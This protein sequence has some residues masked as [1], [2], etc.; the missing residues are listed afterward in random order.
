MISS[1]GFGCFLVAKYSLVFNFN[2]FECIF[3]NFLSTALTAVDDMMA[4]DV[5]N[6]DEFILMLVVVVV[7]AAAFGCV[8]RRPYNVSVL[9]H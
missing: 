1:N 7:A 8:C 2:C 5:F 3:T 9:S 6:T 4:N